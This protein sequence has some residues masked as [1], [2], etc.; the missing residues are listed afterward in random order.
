[1]LE[2]AAHARELLAQEIDAWVASATAEG[3]AYMIPLSYVWTGR[4]MIFATP[5]KSRTM[6]DLR[7]T[8]RTRVSLPSARDVVILDGRVEVMD[9]AIDAAEVEA[10]VARHVWDPR[11]EPNPYAFFRLVP[12]QIQAWNVA[13]ELPT[14][15][16]MRAGRW[17]DEAEALV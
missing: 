12:E 14:R 8:G 9:Q 4:A 2:R 10:F 6:R 1:M 5:E 11:S 15:V 7:R 13:S 3:E 16:V 17:L